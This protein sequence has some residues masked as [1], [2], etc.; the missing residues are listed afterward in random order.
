MPAVLSYADVAKFLGSSLPP[1]GPY[2]GWDV[3]RTVQDPAFPAQAYTPFEYG[4]P[5]AAVLGWAGASAPTATSLVPAS[6][7]V[8][9]ASF[10]LHVH[11]TGF[12]PGSVILWNGTPEPTTF[13]SATELTTGVDMTTATVAA[14][15]PVAV[16]V[17]G[18]LTTNELTFDLQAAP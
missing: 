2:V 4:W 5:V 14:A 8:G 1:D 15:I 16:Q 13:V 9:D 17:A 7:V 12:T 18:V 6:A 3:L 10:T 11:G